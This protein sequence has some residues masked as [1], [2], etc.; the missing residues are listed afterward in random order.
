MSHNSFPGSTCDQPI[1]L[2][3]EKCSA[4]NTHVSWNFTCVTNGADI[5]RL[6]SDEFI[7]KDGSRIE[8]GTFNTAGTEIS[9]GYS[10]AI[11]TYVNSS[12][13]QLESTVH[14]TIKISDLKDFTSSIAT[15]ACN[16]AYENITLSLCSKYITLNKLMP[17]S[18]Y[19][20]FYQ[21]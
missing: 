17:Y 14:V 20:Q 6:S 15:M 13:K 19:V 5:Q 12:T 4:N 2:T 1:C 9:I 21:L 7:G 3:K 10:T 16:G 18:R 11:L 8:F